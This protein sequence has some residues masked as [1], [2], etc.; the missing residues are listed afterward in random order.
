MAIIKF[1]DEKLK[2]YGFNITRGCAYS[3]KYNI[4]GD[5]LAR[6]TTYRLNGK[7]YYHSELYNLAKQM[8]DKTGVDTDSLDALKP[9]QMLSLLQSQPNTSVV[10]TSMHLQASMEHWM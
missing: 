7:P 10:S 2:D 8:N 6:R 3:F 5:E 9:N 1:T 4:N